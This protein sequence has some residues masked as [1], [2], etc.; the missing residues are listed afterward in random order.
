M[1]GGRKAYIFHAG[2][3]Y[4]IRAVR[5]K[6]SQPCKT[7]ISDRDSII[8]WKDIHKAKRA[9]AKFSHKTR[10]NYKNNTMSQN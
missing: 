6:I 2:T 9:Q 1:K 8:I 7:I 10:N 5:R 4:L 3:Y